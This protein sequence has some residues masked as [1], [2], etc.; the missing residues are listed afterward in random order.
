MG[1]GDHT[2]TRRP[3]IPTHRHWIRFPLGT[4]R[5]R[6]YEIESVC[7]EYPFVNERNYVETLGF[8]VT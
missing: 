8:I 6:F 5:R 1:R 4:N 3:S 7:I 2:S